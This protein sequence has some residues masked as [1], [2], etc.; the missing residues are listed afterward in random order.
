MTSLT[1]CQTYVACCIMICD[2]MPSDLFCQRAGLLWPGLSVTQ[3]CCDQVCYDQVCL[4]P[5]LSVTRSVSDQVCCDQVFCDQ[6]CC[7]QVCLWPGLLWP[8]LW[9]VVNR[10]K[11]ETYWRVA[12]CSTVDCLWRVWDIFVAKLSVIC[13]WLAQN[14]VGDVILGWFWGRCNTGIGLGCWLISSDSRHITKT[15]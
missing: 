5:G 10:K 8:G 3:V 15:L 11:S 7:D 2:Q 13:L 1:S 14:L 4:W 6:V 9:Q 12:R